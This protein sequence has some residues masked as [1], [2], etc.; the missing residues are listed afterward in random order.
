[1]ATIG[2]EVSTERWIE[3]PDRVRDIY[4]M[5]R[6]TPLYRAKRLEAALETPPRIYYKSEGVSPAGS[7]S[8]R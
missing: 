6:P 1:M 5:W 2:Q 3:I 7:S 8:S 4:R